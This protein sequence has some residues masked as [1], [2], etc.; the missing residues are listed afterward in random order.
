MR[1]N[2]KVAC[3]SLLLPLGPRWEDRGGG[4]RDAGMGVG[5]ALGG[6]INAS[7]AVCT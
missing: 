3:H 7:V 2:G 5:V 4:G 1:F 6:L